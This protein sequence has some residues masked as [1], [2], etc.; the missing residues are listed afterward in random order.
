MRGSDGGVGGWVGQFWVRLLRLWVGSNFLVG[1]RGRWLV[2]AC[3]RGGSCVCVCVCVFFFFK[4]E[5]RN[6]F[7]LF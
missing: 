6:F 5:G 7:K 3:R 1:F 2:V 4:I